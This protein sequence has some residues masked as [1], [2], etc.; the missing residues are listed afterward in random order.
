MRLVTF[1]NQS[2]TPKAFMEFEDDGRMKPP[3][4]SIVWFM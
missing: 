4:Y 3:P 2:S 1:P